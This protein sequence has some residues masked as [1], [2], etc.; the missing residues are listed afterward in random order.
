MALT[1][2]FA[3]Y[4]LYTVFL[5]KIRK[6]DISIF[7]SKILMEMCQQRA[8][9]SERTLLDSLPEEGLDSPY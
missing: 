2:S 9:T 1:F 4:E 3:P 6:K 5:M 7:M 8:Y